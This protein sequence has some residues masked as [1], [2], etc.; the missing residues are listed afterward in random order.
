VTAT[1][2]AG[3]ATATYTY[4]PPPPTRPKIIK[5]ESHQ[6]GIAHIHFQKE[7]DSRYACRLSTADESDQI[8]EVAGSPYEATTLTPDKIY[9]ATI[10]IETEAGTAESEPVTIYPP[11][12]GEPTVTTVNFQFT[13]ATVTWK[14]A[15]YATM[16]RIKI[17]DSIY[18]THSTEIQIRQLEPNTNHTLQ[19]TAV[20]AHGETAGQVTAFGP[21]PPTAPEP[22]FESPTRLIWQQRMYAIYTLIIDDNPIETNIKSPY[23]LPKFSQSQIRIRAENVNGAATSEPIKAEMPSPSPIRI[24]A[25]TYKDSYP[26]IEWSESEWPAEYAVILDDIEIAATASSPYPIRQITENKKYM[27]KIKASNI[28]GVSYTP[29]VYVLPAAPTQIKITNIEYATNGVQVTWYCD[30][31]VAE[32]TLNIENTI[33]P[34]TENPYFLTTLKQNRT[35]KANLRAK[36]VSGKIDSQP[37]EVLPM[38]P[39]GI[40]LDISEEKGLQW[41]PMTDVEAKYTLMVDDEPL[42]GPLRLKEN[43][44]RKVYVL[45]ENK[46]AAVRSNVVTLWPA[47]PGEITVD[48]PRLYEKEPVLSWTM[49]SGQEVVYSLILPGGETVEN[50]IS[51][52]PL[53]GIDR[54]KNNIL[55]LRAK[56]VSGVREMDIIIESEE[57]S[58]MVI[59]RVGEVIIEPRNHVNDN[60]LKWYLTRGEGVFDIE[61]VESGKRIENVLSGYKMIVAKPTDVR[62][63]ARGEYGESKS[64]IVKIYPGIPGPIHYMYKNNILEWFTEYGLAYYTLYDEEDVIIAEGVTSPY[65]SSKRVKKIEGKSREGVRYRIIK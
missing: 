22:F 43:R 2:A 27:L 36:N 5:A 26:V 30:S 35:Y 9:T 13:T 11:P 24:T 63:V 62:V 25:I 57:E 53:Q 29:E 37:Y 19:V 42:A 51:P 8:H 3:E 4:Y 50:I 54:S 49:K 65:K 21:E 56:N 16:Y 52:Y 7:A 1:N 45:A 20:S 61:E 38:V 60:R 15:A 12:P 14:P 17:D 23:T 39:G 48:Y 59:N 44:S 55:F 28:A 32:V 10:I 41:V 34:L 58:D 33:I 64:D 18:T 40:Q 6:H 46:T 47:R 31:A